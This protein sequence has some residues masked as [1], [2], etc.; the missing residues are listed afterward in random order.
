[1][2]PGLRLMISTTP[3]PEP[4]DRQLVETIRGGDTDAFTVFDPSLGFATGGGTFNLDGD[5]VNFGF[6]MK[7]TKSGTNLQGNLIAV[8]HHPDGTV[9][10]IKSNSLGGLALS[11][12]SG[13]GIA[14]FN[15]KATYS[16]W[17]SSINDYVNTG[18]NTFYVYGKDC[19]NP[20]TGLDY[21]WIDGP[22]NLDMPGNGETGKQQLTGG[23]IAVPHKPAR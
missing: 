9:S 18:N 13:C 8:R 23:N 21:I 14:Q 6:T 7:Y 10:R 22:G 11:E 19:N 12:A 3:T 20:G 15:G 1:M 5:R 17:N 2:S 16:T 4:D